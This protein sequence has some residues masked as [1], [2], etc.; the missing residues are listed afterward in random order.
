M[1]VQSTEVVLWNPENHM[2]NRSIGP[3][4]GGEREGRGAFFSSGYILPS[5]DGWSDPQ[6]DMSL[7]LRCLPW[8]R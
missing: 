5:M 6:L 4:E 7:H 1:Y 8:M 2:G 3:E